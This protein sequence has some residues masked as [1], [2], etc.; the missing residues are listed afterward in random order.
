MDNPYLQITIM[1]L[2]GTNFLTCSRSAVVSDC[3]RGL[4]RYLMETQKKPEEIDPKY[5]KW[6]PGIPS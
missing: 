4:Y 3:S 2:D 6:I 1:K 5:E